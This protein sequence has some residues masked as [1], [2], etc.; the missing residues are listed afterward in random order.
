MVNN[1]TSL[2]MNF[3]V[4]KLVQ[5][6]E[7]NRAQHAKQY[8]EMCCAYRKK[9]IEILKDKITKLEANQTVSG[10]TGLEEPFNY[11]SEYDD[12]L[13]MLKNTS[14]THIELASYQY[15][16]FVMDDW[17]QKKQFTQVGTSYS[18]QH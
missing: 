16:Q 9:C 14:D 11:L 4:K 8:E 1:M 13:H 5:I 10:R 6:L 17:P 2:T 3:E 18:V 7:K 12:A 15:K